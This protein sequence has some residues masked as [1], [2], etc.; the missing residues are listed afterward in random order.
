MLQDKFD[1]DVAVIGTGLAGLATALSLAGGGVSV[2]LLGPFGQAKSSVD[3]RTSALFKASISLLERLGVLDLCRGSIAPLAAIRIIDDTGRLLRAPEILFHAREIGE[4]QF[5][6]NLPNDALA[7]A[8]A[9]KVEAT[10]TIKIVDTAAVTAIVPAADHVKLETRDGV[11]ITARL[12]AGA[13]GRKS[14]ARAAAGLTAKTWDHAQT[15]VVATFEH[16]RA[17]EGISNELHRPAGPLT[18]VPMPGL[19]SSLVWVETPDRARQLMS[20][21]DRDFCAELEARLGGI[22]GRVAIVSP[23]AA[24]PLSSLSTSPL[25][26]HRIALIGEAGHAFPPIGAQGLNLG[27]RDAAE[28][29]D[30]VQSAPADPGAES[31][32]AAYDSARRLDV[33]SRTAAV[34]LLNLSLI[35]NFVP[36]QMARTAGIHALN[37]VGP[38]RR[39]LMR[40]GM[41]PQMPL[42]SLMREEAPSPRK[43]GER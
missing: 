9:R 37:A 8:A 19:A 26:R 4:A 23:R 20:L 7:R 24:F 17:H 21:A 1:T 39:L 38:L 29:A 27:L 30:R 40:E 3:Q 43:Q 13:D 35:S 10:P 34:D 31:V 14:A 18:T 12:V 22:L 25:A 28:I 2:C 33:W 42:P 15:A 6:A 36:V 11:T 16:S 32:L 5:G 41:H